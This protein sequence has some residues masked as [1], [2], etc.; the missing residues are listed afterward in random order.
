L[1]P[2][3]LH[4]FVVAIYEIERGAIFRLWMDGDYRVIAVDDHVPCSLTQGKD[5]EPQMMFAR[6]RGG[7]AW[8]CLAEKAFAKVYGS[9]AA[10]VGGNISEAFRDLTGEIV[11]DFKLSDMKLDEKN[12]L[13]SRIKIG[14]ARG[15]ILVGCA[16]VT[17]ND[18]PQQ[19]SL[20]ADKSNVRG[21]GKG[22]NSAIEEANLIQNHAYAVLD[23]GLSADGVDYL[24]IR[25][26]WGNN[27]LLN[28]TQRG[29]EQLRSRK[30]AELDCGCAW[31]AWDVFLRLFNRAYV[32]HLTSLQRRRVSEVAA[33]STP[34]SNLTSLVLPTVSI[35]VAS[36]WKPIDI[37]KLCNSSS[38]SYKS[39]LAA[40]VSGGASH[41]PTWRL[42]PLFRLSI[43]ESGYDESGDP[44]A[45]ARSSA[46]VSQYRIRICLSWKDRRRDRPL[47]QGAATG[48]NTDTDGAEA[49]HETILT[50][51]GDISYPP[52]G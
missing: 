16:A 30:V 38:G 47:L 25:N 2:E 29:A 52:I 1:A 9:Y 40:G 7:N 28:S 14:M 21:R 27:P 24:L 22:D 34:A 45:G 10:I 37:V 23:H 15:C 20:H 11:L 51:F 13:L 48:M 42:N 5:A 4:Q 44:R 39:F 46:G 49:A 50:Q 36:C 33:E 8:V 43:T 12:S 26:P 32:C 18:S 19:P 17:K 41:Y 31:V 6:S 3:L 35:T